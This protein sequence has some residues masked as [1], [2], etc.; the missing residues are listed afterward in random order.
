MISN[1]IKLLRQANQLSLQQLADNLSKDAQQI[2]RAALSN[3]E[4]GKS[5]PNSAMLD[6]L[7]KELGVSTEYLLQPDWDS[8]SLELFAAPDLALL[9]IQEILSYVQLELERH[10]NLDRLLGLQ[11]SWKIPSP[12]YFRPDRP[13]E[14]EQMADEIRMLW[15][16]G[17]LPISSVCGLLESQGIYLFSLPIRF[18]VKMLSGYERSSL[19]PFIFFSPEAFIDDFRYDL[20]KEAGRFFIQADESSEDL[21]LQHFARS[22]LAPRTSICKDFGE[23]RKGISFDELSMAKEKY[24]ISRKNL[25]YRLNEIG[26]VNDEFYNEYRYTFLR[27]HGYVWRTSL[28]SNLTF[29]NERPL[30]YTMKYSRALSE[31]LITS[32]NRPFL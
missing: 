1:R 19:C 5:T 24:G 6:A 25:L 15:E 20:L 32:E 9:R 31:G 16:L 12:G 8:F 23:N 26:I 22:I 14:I 30:L 13:E 28:T 2:T 3:Y 10:L 4:N 18:G 21:R 27:Q 29:F 11:H 17:N 7:S